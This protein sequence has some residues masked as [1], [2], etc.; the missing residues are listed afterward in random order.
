[1]NYTKT[2][3]VTSNS[4]S[5]LNINILDRSAEYQ[6]VKYGV[7]LL[8]TS[9]DKTFI[10][11]SYGNNTEFNL[12]EMYTS[13]KDKPKRYGFYDNKAEKKAQCLEANKYRKYPIGC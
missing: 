8:N 12:T 1:M 7:R 2:F 6:V 10:L 11:Q 3:Y 13:I 5:Y 4:F 9:I